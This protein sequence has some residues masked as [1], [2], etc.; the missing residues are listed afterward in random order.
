MTHDEL[1]QDPDVKARVEAVQQAH[2]GRRVRPIDS[3]AGVLVCVAPTRQQLLQFET[4]LWGDDATAKA[5]AHEDLLKNCCAD[6]DRAR[7]QALLEE[8]PGICRDPEVIRELRILYGG[9]KD[10]SAKK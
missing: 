6:P 1:L 7:L 9:A 10:S 8:W 5:R 2:P 4:L 3:A